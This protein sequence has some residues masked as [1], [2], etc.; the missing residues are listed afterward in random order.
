[1][2]DDNGR[3][4]AV[5]SPTG[6]AAIYEYDPAGNITAIRRNTA[7]TLEVLDFSP[8]EGVAGNQVTIVG[9]GFGAGV[10]S[11]SFNGAAAQIVSANAPV[12]VVTVPS[13][14]TTGPISVATPG[15]T[16]TTAMPFTVKG[17]SL[18]PSTAT[19]FSDQTVQFNAAVVLPG[20]PGIAWSVDGIGDGSAV[21]GTISPAGLYTAP[22]LPINQPNAVFH[23]E[24]TSVSD[25]SVYGE[26]QVTVRNPEF[27]HPVYAQIISVR[28]GSLPPMNATPAFSAAL[29]VRNGSLSPMNATPAF[30]AQVSVTTSPSVSAIAP[31]QIQRGTSANIT[32]TGANLSGASAFSFINIAAAAFDANI[33]ASNINVN[34]GG[35]SL[36]ATLTV[37]GGA[38]TGRRV[39]IVTAG[40]RM[41]PSTDIVANTIEII[42]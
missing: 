25:A 36:T 21:V 24:A 16:A 22:K 7:A 9:T 3:L 5:I 17:I 35:T 2:Y 31:V 26:A 20:N 23:V 29:S 33:T 30:S 32:I 37:T 40:G 10:N 1:V 28:N 42:P 38:A 39:V 19:V 41:S 27:L 12:I 4:H 11:V 13:G 34:G 6:E 18:T 8:R 14:A 15:G